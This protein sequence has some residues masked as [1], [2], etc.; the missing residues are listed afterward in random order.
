MNNSL[1]F[2]LSLLSTF[3]V[4]RIFVLIAPTKTVTG[5]IRHKTLLYF[6]H[7][8]IGIIIMAIVFPL[9]LK[10]GLTTLLVSLFAIGLSLSLDE[11][12]AWL[13][14]TEYPKR[15]EFTLTLIFL[16]VFLVYLYLL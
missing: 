3:V 13:L 8:Y 10:Y 2:I 4:V 16:A 12:A 11:L 9:I 7:I 1:I 15:K 6:H 5:Y 14:F